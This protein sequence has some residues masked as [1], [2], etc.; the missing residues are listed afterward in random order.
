MP[1]TI[2][3][4]YSAS[5]SILRRRLKTQSIHIFAIPLFPMEAYCPPP[6][7]APLIIAN[8]IVRIRP[9]RL[10]NGA[11]YCGRLQTLGPQSGYVI[12]ENHFTST[13]SIA[14]LT[15]PVW[16]WSTEMIFRPMNQRQYWS[17][18]LLRSCQ[19][20]A[21]ASFLVRESSLSAV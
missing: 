17:F 9:P 18:S 10:E 16:L 13:P 3:L 6:G 14:V 8:S 7:K 15:K 21:K 4:L 5:T 12:S 19:S 11:I 1:V 2:S 20:D